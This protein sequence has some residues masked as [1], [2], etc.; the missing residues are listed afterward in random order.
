MHKN[1][2]QDD[3][4]IISQAFITE[5]LQQYVNKKN[6]MIVILYSTN[7]DFMKIHVH[8]NMILKKD[9]QWIL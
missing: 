4:Q 6:T 7:V 5:V 9:L 2:E 1:D 8:M 3:P